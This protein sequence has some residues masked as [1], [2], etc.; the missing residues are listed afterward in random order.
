MAP[1][2]SSHMTG[3]T[4]KIIL[5][6]PETRPV[7][8]LFLFDLTGFSGVTRHSPISTCIQEDLF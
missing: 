6:G 3:S 1:E 4:A 5:S 8:G 7:A 2:T